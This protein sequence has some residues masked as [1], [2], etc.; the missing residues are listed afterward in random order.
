MVIPFQGIHLLFIGVGSGLVVIIKKMVLSWK[1]MG[2]L[3]EE[4][5]Q[6]EPSGSLHSSIIPSRIHSA[7]ECA[8]VTV[9]CQRAVHTYFCSSPNAC[10]LDPQDSL[11]GE[12][13][14]PASSCRSRNWGS[15]FFFFFFC[16]LLGVSSSRATPCIPLNPR[17]WTPPLPRE[18]C[19]L[20]AVPCNERQ[21]A[22]NAGTRLSNFLRLFVTRYLG[23]GYAEHLGIDLVRAVGSAGPLRKPQWHFRGQL[24]LALSPPR[25]MGS[26]SWS[27]SLGSK[28]AGVHK[29]YFSYENGVL[30][31]IGLCRL[32]VNLASHGGVRLAWG[33]LVSRSCLNA[34][35]LITLQ[36]KCIIKCEL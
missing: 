29:V 25:T 4:V 8:Y 33:E 13:L 20:Q 15:R 31:F 7:N 35:V 1:E 19:S 2:I 21:K 32:E 26:G 10:V 14:L 6:V 27:W 3:T 18:I 12:A 11:T 23:A 28:A 30:E 5:P 16:D 34:N 36:L 24:A 9:W 22:S 17:H